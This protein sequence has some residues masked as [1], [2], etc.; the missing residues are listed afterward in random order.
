MATSDAAVVNQALGYVGHRQFLDDL[1]EETE[2]ASVARRFYFDTRDALL[3]EWWWTFATAR[4]VLAE[5]TEERSGWEYCYAVPA[6]C[7]EARF[8]W[9]GDPNPAPETRVPFELELRS[10]G[11]GML[12]LT[13]QVNA[14]LVYT[15]RVTAAGLW[16]AHFVKALAL[17]L[18][19]ELALAL[20]VKPGLAAGLQPLA[21]SALAQAKALDGNANTPSARPAPEHIRARS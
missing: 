2:A 11:A 14:E 15:K 20:A 16:P 6:D 19:V 18:A 5:A 21:S 4:V 9:N 12:L 7:L 17:A 10:D 8:I 13:N 3:R 1:T